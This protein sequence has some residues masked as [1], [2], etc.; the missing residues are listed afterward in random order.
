[1][2]TPTTI[3]ELDELRA[4]TLANYHLGGNPFGEMIAAWD[5]FMAANPLSKAKDED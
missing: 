4:R 5:G 2:K 1:M 3:E